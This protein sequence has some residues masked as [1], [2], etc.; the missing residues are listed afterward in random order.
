[1]KR[2]ML[3][4]LVLCSIHFWGYIPL[5]WHRNLIDLT[6]LGIMGISFV[7]VIQQRGLRFKSSIILFFIGIVFNII[8][9]YFNH[10]QGI[11]D[12][13]LS[14]GYFYFIVFYFW[15]HEYKIEKKD[16]ENLIIA[17]AIIYVILNQL[18]IQLYPRRLFHGTMFPD[19]GTIRMRVQGASFLVLAYFM[20]LNRYLLKRNL[21]HIIL[22]AV[23][24]F[25][26][27]RMGSRTFTA[28]AILLSGVVFIKLIRYSAMNYFLVVL[29]V[30]L[31]IGMLQLEEPQRIIQGMVAT[32]EEQQEMGDRYIRKMQFRYFTNEYPQNW[33]YYIVGGGF[34]GGYGTYAERMGY[35]IQE[36]GFYWVDLGL[37]GFYLVVGMIATLGMLS[38]VIRGIFIKLPK[39]MLY[40]NIYFAYLL[41]VSNVVM[42]EIFAP[43]IFGIQALAL[44]L[45]DLSKDQFNE[46]TL[47]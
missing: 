19:R 20:L 3:V 8:S 46:S 2:S 44:Y 17:F 34:P 22:A 40:L 28:G 47:V 35:M 10:G 42:D 18:Q 36:Y 37:L 13:T 16:L 38:W 6:S 41:L 25:V 9:A 30:V 24:L 45:I 32:T 31:F 39:D 33:S 11:R 1:M 26:I 27:I 14:F 43:G 7:S 23:F 5:W 21:L 15:L 4:I 12:T 29:A